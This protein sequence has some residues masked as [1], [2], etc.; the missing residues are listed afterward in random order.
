TDWQY[1]MIDNIHEYEAAKQKQHPV[2]MTFQWRGG[3]NEVLYHSPADWI[4]P[5]QGSS[6]ENFLAEPSGAYHGKV[7]V[8]DTD[9]LCGH[10]CGDTLWVW[11]SFCRGLNVLMLDDL[12]P[13]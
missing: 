3:S 6:D 2:G 8:S 10:T 9:H 13:S 5:N 7:L 11:K 12:S 1:H 4:S